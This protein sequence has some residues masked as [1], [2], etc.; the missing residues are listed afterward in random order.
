MR[1]VVTFIAFLATLVFTTECC[2]LAY[3][4]YIFSGV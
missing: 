3:V 1:R 2:F 4:V